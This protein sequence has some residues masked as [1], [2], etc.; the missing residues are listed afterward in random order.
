MR[1]A[2]S[3]ADE[4]QASLDV[5]LQGAEKTFTNAEQLFFEAELL[6][7][8]GALARA[9][10]LHQISLEECSKVNNLG[11]WGVS[12]VLGLEVDQKKV[13]AAFAR[14][15]S[16]NKSNAYMLE[17]SEEER[18]A[19]ARGDWKGAIEAFRRTQDEFHRESNQNKNASFYVDWVGGE[20]V[21]P[22]ERITGEMLQEITD[23]NAEFLGYAQNEL[24]A[25]RTLTASPDVL[26]DLLSDV[27]EESEKLRAE[28]PDNLAEAMDA[29]LS[30]FL[31]AGK[32]KSG[33]RA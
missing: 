24:N 30:R 33:N 16:K 14:H 9:L 25:L 31:E 11:A 27:V 26:R 15:S 6:A 3:K 13:L 1:V 18:E 10:C 21:A 19:R 32:A 17:S 28:K 23:R 20:F 4:N 22:N 5:L 2:D 8:A 29:M 12:L 7:K